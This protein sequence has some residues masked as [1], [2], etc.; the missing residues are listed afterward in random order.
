MRSYK[1]R[2]TGVAPVY[3]GIKFARICERSSFRYPGRSKAAG[4]KHR[5]HRVEQLCAVR[6]RERPRIDTEESQPAMIEIQQIETDSPR[7]H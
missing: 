5:Q 1:H 2:F 3:E 6:D 7:A 4:L